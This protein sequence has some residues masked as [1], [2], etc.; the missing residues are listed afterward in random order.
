MQFLC[1]PPRASIAR[2]PELGSFPVDPSSSYFHKGFLGSPSSE[3]LHRLVHDKTLT[4]CM[5]LHHVMSFSFRRQLPGNNVPLTHS[6]RREVVSGSVT[7]VLLWQLGLVS[8]GCQP[9]VVREPLKTSWINTCLISYDFLSQAGS[10]CVS[11][12]FGNGGLVLAVGPALHTSPLELSGEVQNSP[13]SFSSSEVR[14][15]QMAPSG[16]IPH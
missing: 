10:L 9:G 5:S 16:V 13:A 1:R 8:L 4:P 14:A 15:H 2:S 11:S 7:G 6:P 3:F 12:A